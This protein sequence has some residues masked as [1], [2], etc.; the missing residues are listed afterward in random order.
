MGLCNHANEALSSPDATIPVFHRISPNSLSRCRLTG[1]PGFLAG[2]RRRASRLADLQVG[3]A[4]NLS[5]SGRGDP[6]KMRSMVNGRLISTGSVP[7]PHDPAGR[8]RHPR[9]FR[10]QPAK[11]GS[12]PVE[13]IMA[14]RWRRRHRMGFRRGNALEQPFLAIPEANPEP[15]AFLAEIDGFDDLRLH[16]KFFH[17]FCLC[18]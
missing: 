15:P 16:R 8:L 11:P 2:V 1:R 5:P 9:L 4:D 6:T 17:L 3:S 7:I 14:G 10:P 13:V 18:F 12:D